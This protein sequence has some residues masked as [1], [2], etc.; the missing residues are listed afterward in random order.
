MDHIVAWL[1]EDQA[2]RFT[3]LLDL[4]IKN[5]PAEAHK[6]RKVG[7]YRDPMERMIELEQ[8]FDEEDDE[9]ED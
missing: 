3:G 6:R 8:N 2:P 4:C 9:D 5:S 1:E 7:A